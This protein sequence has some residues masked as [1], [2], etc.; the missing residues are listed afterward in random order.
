MDEILKNEL[1]Q[2]F[3][4]IGAIAE[5]ASATGQVSER[6]RVRKIMQEYEREYLKTATDTKSLGAIMDTIKELQRRVG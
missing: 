4:A 5:R 6:I 3:A 2:P 1:S